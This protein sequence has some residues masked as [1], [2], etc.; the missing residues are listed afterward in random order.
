MYVQSLLLSVIPT[1]LIDLLQVE[2]R[3]LVNVDVHIY[4][5]TWQALE[6]TSVEFNVRVN[7]AVYK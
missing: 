3:E 6:I 4:A 1:V 2:Q 5:F 7:L